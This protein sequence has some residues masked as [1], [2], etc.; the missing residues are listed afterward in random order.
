M[1]KILLVEDNPE[2]QLVIQKWLESDKHVVEAVTSGIEAMER[3]KIYAYDLL[4]TDWM[5]PGMTGV[6]IVTALRTTGNSI[7]VLMMTC[8]GAIADKEVG[9]H[10][11][12]DDYLTKPFDVKELVMRVKA[13]LRRHGPAPSDTL[14]AGNLTLDTAAHRVCRDN[15]EIMLHP[16]EYAILEFLMR[17][18]GQVFDAASLLNHVWPASSDTSPESIRGHLT[19]LRAK[20][21]EQGKSSLIRTI[22]GAGYMLEG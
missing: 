11:G 3:L 15:Q 6:E 19:R 17:H 8:R 22:Y 21:D 10:S 4:V 5:L 1:A 20:I 9:F 18:P 2:L 12:A 14:R 13:L 16:K 7:P